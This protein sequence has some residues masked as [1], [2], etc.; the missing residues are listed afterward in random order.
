MLG[1]AVWSRNIGV[2]ALAMN[3]DHCE[4]PAYARYRRPIRPGGPLMLE[5][6]LPIDRL[7][8]R[9]SDAGFPVGISHHAGTFVCNHVFYVGL[10][11]SRPVPCGFIHLPPAGVVRVRDQIRAIGLVLEEIGRPQGA[12]DVP[13]RMATSCP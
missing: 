4:D 3:L 5:S 9:L 11:K 12:Q 10:S 2:E 8:R 13:S 6:R 1:L 7:V